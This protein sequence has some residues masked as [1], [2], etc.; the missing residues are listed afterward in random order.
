MLRGLEM[1]VRMELHSGSQK[2]AGN[3]L[4][5]KQARVSRAGHP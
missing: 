2:Q 1:S 5:A 3:F 4:D